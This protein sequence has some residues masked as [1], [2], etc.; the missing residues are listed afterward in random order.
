MMTIPTNRIFM[1]IDLVI[2]MKA[3]MFSNRMEACNYRLVSLQYTYKW[4]NAGASKKSFD[5]LS[6]DNLKVNCIWFEMNSGL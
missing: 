5:H 6:F 2:S 4:S 3:E 1:Y